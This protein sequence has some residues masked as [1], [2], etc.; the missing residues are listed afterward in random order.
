ML[1]KLKTFSEDFTDFHQKKFGVMVATQ[2]PAK[3]I[4][5]FWK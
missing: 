3:S 2:K 5:G 1:W 4:K